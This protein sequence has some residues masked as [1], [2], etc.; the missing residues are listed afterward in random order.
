MRIVFAVS[1]VIA[2][3]SSASA[4][5]ALDHGHAA[6]A[7]QAIYERQAAANAKASAILNGTPLLPSQKTDFAVGGRTTIQVVPRT[8]EE[9]KA[10]RLAEEA[11][12]ARCK[13][14]VEEDSD[15]I[16]RTRYAAKDCDLDRFNTA[17]N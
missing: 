6:D 3:I 4:Q 16:R 7:V 5:F 8:E 15:G 10:D 14:T 17:G 12:S 2:S 13:P 11:W 1:I 9:L